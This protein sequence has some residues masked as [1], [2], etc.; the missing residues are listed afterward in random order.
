MYVRVERIT[1]YIKVRIYCS[2]DLEP[3]HGGVAFARD[4]KKI[5][6]GTQRLFRVI[7]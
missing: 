3:S 1:T 5:L 2:L 6:T 7:G 4:D